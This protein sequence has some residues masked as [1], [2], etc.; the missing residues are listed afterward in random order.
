MIDDRC[1]VQSYSLS[2]DLW[3]LWLAEDPEECNPCADLN[4]IKL[5]PARVSSPSAMIMQCRPSGLILNA[6]SRPN[7]SDKSK[8]QMWESQECSA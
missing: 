4:L 2:D 1:E 8:R 7:K 3:Y 6:C 5:K